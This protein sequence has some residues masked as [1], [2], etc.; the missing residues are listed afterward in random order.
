MSVTLNTAG[1]SA[2]L[3]APDGPV[4]R[5]V[6]QRAEQVSEAARKRVRFIMQRSP[7]GPIV[8]SDVGFAPHGNGYEI[9][10]RGSGRIDF[11][12]AEK[13]VRE[14]GVWLIPALAEVFPD[15]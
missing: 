14:D 15:V 6:R 2:L 9:G 10:I 7:L 3:E 5:E 1:L 13:E 4:G 12:L 8:S 11:Y